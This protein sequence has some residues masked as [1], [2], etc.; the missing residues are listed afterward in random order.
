M[1]SSWNLKYTVAGLGSF[2]KTIVSGATYEDELHKKLLFPLKILI[3]TSTN[4]VYSGQLNI[5]WTLGIQKC[6]QKLFERTPSLFTNYSGVW[7]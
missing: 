5:F 7:Q 6:V 4:I 1:D 2:E 3:N